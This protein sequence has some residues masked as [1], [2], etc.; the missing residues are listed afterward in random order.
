MSGCVLLNE[1]GGPCRPPLRLSKPPGGIGRPQPSGFRS[2]PGNV[3]AGFGSLARKAQTTDK[4]E[5]QEVVPPAG[6]LGGAPKLY[7]TTLSLRTNE[8]P[9]P[10]DGG[11]SGFF[12]SLTT[13]KAGGM[14][15]AFK[16]MILAAPKGALKA[17]QPHHHL[18]P[19]LKRSVFYAFGFLSGLDFLSGSNGSRYSLNQN[20][21][22]KALRFQP[23]L[24]SAPARSGDF[25][26]F[27]IKRKWFFP[28]GE[29]GKNVGVKAE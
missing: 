15:H 9:L 20:R 10:D 28:P 29:Q 6:V 5:V 17:W 11:Q 3:Y 18:G 26:F 24:R 22:A 25:R 14:H 7:V 23:F 21:R 13:S 4:V 12:D 2:E 16:A 8:A 1:S 19:P 27:T